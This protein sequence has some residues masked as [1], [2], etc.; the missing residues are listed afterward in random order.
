MNTDISGFI[1]ND[2]ICLFLFELISIKKRDNQIKIFL[3]FNRKDILRTIC[4]YI[5]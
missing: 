4:E 2:F 1:K 5:G 3:L